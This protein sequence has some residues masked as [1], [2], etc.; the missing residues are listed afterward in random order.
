MKCDCRPL[1]IRWYTKKLCRSSAVDVAVHKARARIASIRTELS[2]LEA[3]WGPSWAPF[4]HPL[5]IP[6]LCAGIYRRPP[7]TPVV[8]SAKRARRARKAGV[9]RKRTVKDEALGSPGGGGTSSGVNSIAARTGI[10]PVGCGEG[11]MC[12]NGRAQRQQ[13][14][15]EVDVVFSRG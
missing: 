14:G 7:D 12:T 8:Q 4:R 15:F 5:P 3:S 1:R 11:E 6:V 13:Q 10:P 9:K 2:F